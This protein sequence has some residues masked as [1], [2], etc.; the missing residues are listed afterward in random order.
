MNITTE[1]KELGI[2]YSCYDCKENCKQ[3]LTCSCFSPTEVFYGRVFA[4]LQATTPLSND[5]YLKRYAKK[6][7]GI[8]YDNDT[9][10][11]YYVELINDTLSQI[12]NF[13]P[14]YVF[15]I[16]QIRDVLRFE[17]DVTISRYDDC[18]YEIRLN[19]RRK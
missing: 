8:T 5:Y 6:S 7:C 18:C 19:S 15:T 17:P 13:E 14:A 11:S 12:R 2:A 4:L 10:D 3:R 9:T 16:G 1:C